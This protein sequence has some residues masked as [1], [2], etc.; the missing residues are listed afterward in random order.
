MKVQFACLLALVVCCSAFIKGRKIKRPNCDTTNGKK[1]DGFSCGDGQCIWKSLRCDGRQ[2]CFNS[3]DEEEILCAF[4]SYIPEYVCSDNE[5]DCGNGN[6][7][8]RKKRC[9]GQRECDNG[10][11]EKNCDDTYLIRPNC[12]EENGKPVTGVDCGDGMCIFSN[13]LCDDKPDCMNGMDESPLTCPDKHKDICTEKEFQCA[14]SKQCVP[15]TDRCDGTSDCKNNYDE[16]NCPSKKCAKGKI[17]CGDGQCYKVEKLCD[18]E[19]DCFNRA[20]EKHCTPKV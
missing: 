7:I 17:D 16:H 14:S 5:F 13:Q 3:F 1:V 8:N 12:D 19:Q 10:K 15:L 20:D 4:E 6:C 9:D 18:G 2:D 11:D